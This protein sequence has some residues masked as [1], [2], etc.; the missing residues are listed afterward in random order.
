MGN[1]GSKTEDQC[2]IQDHDSINQNDLDGTPVDG[3]ALEMERQQTS[4]SAGFIEVLSSITSR[5][6]FASSTTSKS[7][8]SFVSV[9]IGHV[10]NGFITP[11]DI[12]EEQS[13]QEQQP[14]FC[15][16][17]SDTTKTP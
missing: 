12:K 8:G 2:A 13:N 11:L 4:V 14:Q 15:N 7:T 5:E 3:R 16:H 1:T 17:V 10:D 6:N 9:G